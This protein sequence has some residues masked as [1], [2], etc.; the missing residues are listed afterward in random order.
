MDLSKG[1]GFICGQG[2]VK[3]R[4]AERVVSKMLSTDGISETHQIFVIFFLQ[5]KRR[6]EGVLALTLLGQVLPSWRASNRVGAVALGCWCCTGIRRRAFSL[7]KLALAGFWVSPGGC[8]AVLEES[9]CHC[10]PQPPAAEGSP[11]APCLRSLCAWQHWTPAPG[12]AMMWCLRSFPAMLCSVNC[13]P[14]DP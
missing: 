2:K 9:L 14:M 11:A 6:S 4:E 3:E 5:L 12:C 10:H 7:L 1:V 13:P 8:V